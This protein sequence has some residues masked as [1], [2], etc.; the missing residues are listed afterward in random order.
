[1]EFYAGSITVSFE[2]VG[3]GFLAGCLI[4]FPP[5]SQKSLRSLLILK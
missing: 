4:K 5:T 2:F 1:M 3:T